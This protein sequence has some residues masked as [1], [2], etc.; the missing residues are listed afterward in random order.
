MEL[1]TKETKEY[2]HFKYKNKPFYF[3]VPN[4]PCLW[5]VQTITSKEPWTIEWIE[6]FD[7][8]DVFWDVGANVGMY[9]IYAAVMMGVRTFAFE[10]EAANYKVLNENI[11]VNNLTDI[12]RAYCIGISDK[13]SI[14]EL[15]VFNIETGSSNH[16]V[17]PRDRSA[18]I[19]GIT[20]YTLDQLCEHLPKPT[21]LKIDVDGVEPLIVN[22]GL[23]IALPNVK[24]IM[25]ELNTYDR[26]YKPN[27][28][29]TVKPI[30]E[31]QGFRW[32]PSVSKRSVHKDGDFQ[33][34]GEHLFTR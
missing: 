5:R 12:V 19:Q 17:T 4:G 22:G 1:S 10:P 8:S 6:T 25:I 2:C 27:T 32:D 34:T 3:Y 11:R 20:T 9:T 14:G 33:G 15:S 31:S 26:P 29:D 23:N 21:R 16:Q 13:F 28:F 24:S 7:S 30:L 18:F